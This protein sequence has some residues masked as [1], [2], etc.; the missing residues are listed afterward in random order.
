M[1]FRV[2]EN[3]KVFSGREFGWE[4][5]TFTDK[6]LICFFTHHAIAGMAEKDLCPLNLSFGGPKIELA[7]SSNTNAHLLI[8]FPPYSQIGQ[9]FDFIGRCDHISRF[10]RICLFN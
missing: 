1:A 9:H 10:Y 8:S 3:I 4:G 2:T 6:N 7:D 5:E